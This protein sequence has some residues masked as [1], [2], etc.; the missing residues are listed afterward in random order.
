MAK[1]AR[2]AAREHEHNQHCGLSDDARSRQEVGEDNCSEEERCA[3]SDQPVRGGTNAKV[4][5]QEGAAGG[6]PTRNGRR[7]KLGGIL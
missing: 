2:S 5:K 7:V 1:H 6:K 3:K 4:R